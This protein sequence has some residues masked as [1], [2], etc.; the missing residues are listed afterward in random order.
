M[1]ICGRKKRKQEKGTG[2]EQ[3]LGRANL[4]LPGKR[5]TETTE[6]QNARN[7]MCNEAQERR[8]AAPPG[9]LL[10]TQEQEVRV[11]AYVR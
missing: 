9:A 1:P 5:A 4:V 7:N 8:R 6:P 10:Y 2:S 11:S 3:R